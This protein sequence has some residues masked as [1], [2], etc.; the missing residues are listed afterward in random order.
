MSRGV[1]EKVSGR[2]KQ[3]TILVDEQ[4]RE[5]VKADLT[6]ASAKRIVKEFLRF[7]IYLQEAHK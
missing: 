1:K 4:G 7:E 3:E 2:H 6:P 5:W